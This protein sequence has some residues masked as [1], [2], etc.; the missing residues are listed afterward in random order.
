MELDTTA[1]L[2][3]GG[4]L[5]VIGMGVVFS[6]LTI[7]TI[8]L[9]YFDMIERVIKITPHGQQHHPPK[10]EK[11]EVSE[12]VTQAVEEGISPQTIVAISAAI[13]VAID[14]KIVIRRVRYRREP[15]QPTWATQGRATV[16]ASRMVK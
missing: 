6:A 14:K 8:I 7:I 16:M 11:K 5:L 12:S 4:F 15:A 13:A 2:I 1:A 3:E 10:A 9:S